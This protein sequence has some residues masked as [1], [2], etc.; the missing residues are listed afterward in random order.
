MAR[1]L[2][3]LFLIFATVAHLAPPPPATV[4]GR[5]LRADARRNYDEILRQAAAVF[6]EHGPA[7]SLDEVSR[8]AGVA[9]GTL[10]R[11]F[12][13]RRD[14][15][16]SVLR[17]RVEALAARGTELLDAADPFEGLVR[18]L[19]AVLGHASTYRG[20]SAELTT[21]ALDGT[22]DLVAGWHLRMFEVSAALLARAQAAGAVRP[23]ARSAEVLRLVSAI[24]WAS[25][26][27]ADPARQGERL[28]VLVR[29]GLRWSG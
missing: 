10:Y 5:P 9:S 8:R 19:G 11:H 12:P 23:D 15:V 28:L 26:G 21:S 2:N 6:A 14:L 17:D 22:P 13:T 20:L 29:D 7:A 16:E 25:E 24:A 18:W 3:G 1:K 27:S 4:P